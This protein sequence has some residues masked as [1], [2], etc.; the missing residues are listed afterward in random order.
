VKLWDA[1]TGQELLSLRGHTGGVSSVA[2]SPDGQRL[3]SAGWD[4]AVTAGEVKLWDARTGQEVLSLR[5]HTGAVSS[6]AFSP[7]G[8][9][10]ASA[11][12][13]KTVKLWDA[14]TGQELLSLRGHTGGVTSVAFS[15][16]GQKLFGWDVRGLVLA[17]DAKTG[18]HL[19]VPVRLP[20]PPAG[21]GARHPF[22]PLLAMPVLDR[23]ELIDLSPPDAIEFGYRE[24][25]ARFD[26]PWQEEQAIT[27]GKKTNW[28]AAAFH[29]GQLAQ[30]RPNTENYWQKLEAACDKLGNWHL[31]VA[32]CD[33]VLQQDPTL[34]PVYFRRARLRAQLF[35]F[36][37]AT[38]DQL[39]GLVCTH[40]QQQA[41]QRK[42]IAP[43]PKR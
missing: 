25:M 20:S 41:A 19:P 10:L 32:A 4:P 12:Y 24:G 7:D 39:A 40:L 8:Q 43:D 33:S 38:A 15:P 2:F 18:K 30:H 26:V 37:E 14:R 11:S 23:I 16:D 34:A 29:C 31:A 5:G 36:H 21:Y 22:R 13:D 6:V 42:K 28:F 9:R 35:Q 27:H 3:A 1:R 17:W